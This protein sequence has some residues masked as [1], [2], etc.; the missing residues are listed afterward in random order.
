M[1]RRIRA[2]NKSLYPVR[3]CLR[4]AG[5]SHHLET[6]LILSARRYLMKTFTLR[7]SAQANQPLALV[8]GDDLVDEYL[9]WLAG[10]KSEN[11]RLAYGYDLTKL[12]TWVTAQTSQGTIQSYLDLRP[13]QLLQFI[14]WLSHQAVGHTAGS[15]GQ[16][17][18]APTTVRR[19]VRAVTSFYDYLV[20]TERLRSSP[21]PHR[22]AAE[23]PALNDPV[24]RRQSR[25]AA[26]FVPLDPRP[27]AETLSD[28]EIQTFLASLRSKRD[29]ILFEL[30]LVSG[31]RVSEALNLRLPDVQFAEHSLHIRPV[32]ASIPVRAVHNRGPKRASSGI[33]SVH[34]TWL[35]HLNDYIMALIVEAVQ[36]A[37]EKREDTIIPLVP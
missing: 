13:L 9:A 14:N 5:D 34:P 7:T 32:P 33:V 2:A 15:D 21:V 25:T 23:A 36:K 8:V 30:L 10:R 31:I 22:A 26:A 28:A 16:R 4:A 18:L 37:Q 11:T 1:A 27:P 24:R 19:V 29:R 35:A 17:T 20:L 3:R 6:A 12:L